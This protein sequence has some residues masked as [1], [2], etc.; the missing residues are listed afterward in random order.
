[1]A[2]GA[3]IGPSGER[4]QLY[5]ARITLFLAITCVVAASG[6]LI[7]GYDIGI[8]GG[9]TAMDDFLQKFFPVVLRH[10]NDKSRDQDYCKYN[11]EGLTSFTSSLYIAALLASFVASVVTRRYG[12][13]PSILLGGVSF[14]IG[15]ALNAAAVNLAMLILGRIMLGVGVG[16]ANQ[17]VPL[18]LSEMSPPKMRGGLNI[19]FQLAITIGI[20]VANLI[21]YGTAKISGWGWRLSLGLAA[22]PAGLLFVGGLF[23]SETPNSL[24]ERGRLDQGRALLEKVRGTK[25][26]E[27]EFED[28]VQA[29]QNANAVKHPFRN[30]L[31]RRN[32]PQLV[33]AIFIPFFQQLTGINA[34]MFYAPVLFRSIG[35]GSDASLYSAVITGAVNVLSTLVSIASVDKWGRR[36]LFLEG[37]VQMF[38]AQVVIAVIL[39]DKFGGA[40]QLSKGF[41]IFVVVV[42]CVYVSSFAWSWGPLGWLVPSEIFPLETRSAGQ[43][44]TVSVNMLFTFVIAQAFLA[45]LCHFK[46]GIFLFFAGWVVI[47][48][49]FIYFFLPETKGV[50]IEQMINVWRKHWFWS[51]IIPAEDEN[52]GEK[53]NVQ[54]ADNKSKN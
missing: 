16:F 49:V 11:N 10:K 50:A 35:F 18:Y 17:A 27:A 53:E 23:L 46:Y 45:M 22:V 41:S 12:R 3:I 9:V 44:I 32:R 39:G 54:L 36:A 43:S 33:M 5:E 31:K 48:S 14:L 51:Q 40:K 7:F 15:A 25:N 2:G 42:I 37:G 30:I 13:R 28:L 1:M 38:I 4:A 47:M 21:N 8:S 26:V 29:S 20:L 24:V 19:M 34:I 52:P 6:G